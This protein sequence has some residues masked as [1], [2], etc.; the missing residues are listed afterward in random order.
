MNEYGTGVRTITLEDEEYPHQLASL[1]LRPR[2]LLT[3]GPQIPKAGPLLTIT[4]GRE[5]SY[6]G[7][8][9]AYDIALSCARSGICP[10]VS[11]STG[12]DRHALYGAWEG[13]RETL[14]IFDAPL[15]RFGWRIPSAILITPFAD[16]RLD[17]RFRRISSATLCG[18]WG[19]ATLIIEAPGSSASLTVAKAA[20]DGGKEVFVH[21]VGLGSG[22]LCDGSRQLA[23]MGAPLISSYE[24]LAAR[25]GWQRERMV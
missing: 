19:E 25:L 22:R 18:L 7:R 13:R 4:G 16:E 3:R 6:E 10:V 14:V 15:P 24:E 8:R 9:A 17:E 21:T 23:E 1:R 5:A 20:L 2:L 11:S 12:I